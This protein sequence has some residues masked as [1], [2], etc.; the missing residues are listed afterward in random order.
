MDRLLAGAA[1]AVHR[2]SRYLVRE[3]R[4][5]EAVTGH[6]RPL[7]SHLVHIAKDNVL[8]PGRLDAGPL[9]DL[10]QHQRPQVVGVNAGQH[11]ILAAH[12]GADRL[13]DDYFSHGAPPNVNVTPPYSITRPATAPVSL[14]L[15]PAIA[16]HQ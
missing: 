16:A 4:R 5:Q 11:P 9:H 6:V 13:Y 1:L 7:L 12:G 14:A 8:H 10:V 2:G 3:V 15:A